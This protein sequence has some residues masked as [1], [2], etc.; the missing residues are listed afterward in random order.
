MSLLDSIVGPSF[1][2]EPVGRVVVFGGDRRNR[3]YLV[4][5]PAEELKIS[6]FLKMFF[7]AQI[8]ILLLGYLLASE[9]SRELVY[10]LGRPAAHLIRSMC[11]CMVIYLLV[12]GLPYLLLWRSYKK[13]LLSFVSAEDEVLVSATRPSRPRIL[14]GVGLIALAVLILF[15][16]ILL[17]RFK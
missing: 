13:A 15:G 4:K 17:I 5:S 11:I 10:S 12:A 6:S 16:V 8:S 9:W 1:R 7:C 14:V 2:N 3:G